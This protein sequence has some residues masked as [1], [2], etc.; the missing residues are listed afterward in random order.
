MK[1]KAYL[2]LQA[3]LGLSLAKIYFSTSLALRV[4]N[5]NLGKIEFRERI[6]EIIMLLLSP[7]LPIL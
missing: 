5:I 3:K 2:G 7:I 4:Q 6:T 1:I